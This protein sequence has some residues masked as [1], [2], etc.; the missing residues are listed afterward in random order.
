MDLTDE[1]TR[2]HFLELAGLAATG[3]V[4]VGG[5]APAGAT[6]P[7]G[8]L[9]REALAQGRLEEAIALT[10]TGPTDFHI[11]KVTFAPGADSGWHTHPAT[12]LD[13]LTAGTMTVYIGGDDGVGC[14]PR[15]VQAGQ[16]I[17]VPAGVRH[18]ARNEGTA[19]AEAFVTYLVTAGTDPRVDADAPTDCGA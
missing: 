6:P 12:A 16:A 19:P 2:R 8:S 7:T 5:T 18:L 14:Q 15:V 13:I 1:T 4:V 17:F 11:H 9:S 3:L 10:T